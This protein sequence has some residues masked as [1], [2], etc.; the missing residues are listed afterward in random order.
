M[1]MP[2]DRSGRV[3]TRTDRARPAGTLGLLGNAS[4]ELADPFEIEER[5]CSRINSAA[6][7]RSSGGNKQLCYQL[8][9]SSSRLNSPSQMSGGHSNLAKRD[10]FS[11]RPGSR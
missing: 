4:S 10:G 11:V 3:E 7:Y 1:A 2:P 6:P 8:Y 5:H 9:A